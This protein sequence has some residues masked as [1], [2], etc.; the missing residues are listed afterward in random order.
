MSDQQSIKSV[1]QLN[2]ISKSSSE[3]E[4]RSAFKSA[5][6]DKQKVEKAVTSVQ[7]KQK[8]EELK[9]QLP[10]NVFLTDARLSPEGIESLL[11]IDLDVDARNLYTLQVNRKQISVKQAL[12]IF[13]YAVIFAFSA[14]FI[15]MYVQGFGIFHPAV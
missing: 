8:A 7:Q 13:S 10:A 3:A 1:M 2:G 14:L 11:G 15:V 9:Q 5:K 12:L 6:W 4:L